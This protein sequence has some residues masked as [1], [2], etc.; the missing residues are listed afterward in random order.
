V[1]VLDEAT[2]EAGSAHAVELERA[3]AAATEGRTTLIV[4]HRLTQAATADQIA[5]MEGG[6]IV[7]NGTHIELLGHGG[8][9]AQ[10]WAAWSA[11]G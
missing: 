6:R 11:P 10:L 3:A 2:A 8:R 4:A 1:V 5:V 9:Y 7:E